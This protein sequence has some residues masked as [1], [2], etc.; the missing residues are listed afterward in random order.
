MVRHCMRTN[1]LPRVACYSRTA[2]RLPWPPARPPTRICRGA[3]AAVRASQDRRACCYG[4]ACYK[5]LR[6]WI[7]A[8]CREKI[9]RRA[10]RFLKPYATCHGEAR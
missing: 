6:S 7:H 9:S 8:V 3:R 10:R 4:I 2:V 5:P 1:H